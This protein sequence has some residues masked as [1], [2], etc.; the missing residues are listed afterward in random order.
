MAKPEFDPKDDVP[1]EISERNDSLPENGKDLSKDITL[2][3]TKAIG[4]FDEWNRKKFENLQ[5]NTH[6][7][8]IEYQKLLAHYHDELERFKGVNPREKKEIENFEKL[9]KV[10]NEE[11]AHSA[12]EYD[13]WSQK[14]FDELKENAQKQ[15]Y[16]YEL[17]LERYKKQLEGYREHGNE[18]KINED[19]FKKES[20][21]NNFKASDFI[22]DEIK[23]NIDVVRRIIKIKNQK[24]NGRYEK[25]V[26]T[27][28]QRKIIHL[29]ASTLIFIAFIV[30]IIVSLKYLFDFNL[31]K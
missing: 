27:P 16:E 14:K 28:F 10:P 23:R 6:Q 9:Y 29:L 17:L 5:A 26:E 1:E 13:N 15:F 19:S 24:R 3:K 18:N 4:K 20:N 25:N 8:L 11:K 21:Q 30:F 31:L 7:Q 2:K 22:I 12:E